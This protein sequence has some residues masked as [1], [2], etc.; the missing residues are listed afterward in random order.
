MLNKDTPA[1]WCG[2]CQ[3]QATEEGRQVGAGED[4][5]NDAAEM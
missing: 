3:T 5:L 1:Q 4:I 2:W